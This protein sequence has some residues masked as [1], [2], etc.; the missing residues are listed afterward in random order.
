MACFVVFLYTA[1]YEKETK[2][3]N[4]YV[5][6]RA[7]H[8]LLTDKAASAEGARNELFSAS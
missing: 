4:R 6:R 8:L 2:G 7:K 3:R 5:L 1:Q